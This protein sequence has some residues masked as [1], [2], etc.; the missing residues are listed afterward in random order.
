MTWTREHIPQLT[1]LATHPLPRGDVP[2][3]LLPPLFV[4]AAPVHPA[5]R[6]KVLVRDPDGPARVVG[7]APRRAPEQLAASEPTLGR[8]WPYGLAGSSWSTPFKAVGDWFSAAL[9]I[10]TPGR[11]LEYRLE[12]ERAGQ[13]LAQLPV[14]GSWLLL[15]PMVPSS[16]PVDAA[17]QPGQQGQT[18]TIGPRW[19][20]DMCFFGAL[21]VDLGAEVVGA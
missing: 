9:P 1:E 3:G 4:G 19:S 18:R 12:L 7:A 2:A 8:A 10:L 11:P 16:A 15:R 5:N 20:Y 17:E 21:T 6:V 13:R 14:D